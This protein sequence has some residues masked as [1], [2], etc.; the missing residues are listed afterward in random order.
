ME[1]PTVTNNI[2]IFGITVD[3]YFLDGAVFRKQKICLINL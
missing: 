1:T 3:D 2:T